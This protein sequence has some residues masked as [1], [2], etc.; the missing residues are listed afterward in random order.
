MEAS[1]A[2]R[3]ALVRLC[4]DGPHDPAAGAYYRAAAAAH[5]TLAAGIGPYSLAPKAP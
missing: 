1:A 5:P 3:T 2:T 4:L